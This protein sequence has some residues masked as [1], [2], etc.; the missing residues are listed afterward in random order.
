MNGLI[1][2]KKQGVYVLRADEII[3]MEK[4]LRKINVHTADRDV[5]FYGSFSEIMPQ[6][7]GRFMCCHRSY[8]INM[9]KIIWMN[10]NEICVA[11]DETIFF[12]RD[13]FIKARRIFGRYLMD[14]HPENR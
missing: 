11:G 1:I 2:R 8:L 14:E 9:D 4:K 10:C 7:D 12:G 6:L 3:Y 13:S 5:E